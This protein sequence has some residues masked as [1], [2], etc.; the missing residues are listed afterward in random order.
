MNTYGDLYDYVEA[1]WGEQANKHSFQLVE[2]FCQLHR[3]ECTTVIRMLQAWG[4]NDDFEVYWNVQGRVPRDADIAVFDQTPA[5][6][7]SR[8]GLYCRRVSTGW[9]PCER[10]DVGATLDVS[11]AIEQ[12]FQAGIAGE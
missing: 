11:T 12:M 7:A 1:H 10:T 3:I 9:Q 8:S 2:M 5:E 6:W 4:G